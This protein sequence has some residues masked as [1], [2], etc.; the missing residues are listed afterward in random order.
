MKPSVEIVVA[1]ASPLIA[2][3]RLDALHL[4]PALFSR[5]WMTETVLAECCA[6]SVR[7]E[8]TAIRTAIG[9]GQLG[10]RPT[11]AHPAWTVDPGEASAIAAALELSAGIVMDDRAGRRLAGHLGLPVVGTLGIRVLAKR[12][13]LLSEIGPSVAALAASG[14]YLADRV[15]ESALRLVGKSPLS[16]SDASS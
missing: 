8:C 9:A 3:A 10:V 5:A 15:I 1:D 7:R 11:P 13:R 12:A 4:L 16:A 6:G 2:L 14:Y